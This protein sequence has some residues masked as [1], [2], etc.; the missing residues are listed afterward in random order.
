MSRSFEAFQ[1]IMDSFKTLDVI[2]TKTLAADKTVI[3]ITDMVNGFAHFGALSSPRVAKIAKPI[4][5]FVGPLANRG[6]KVI[7]FADAHSQASPEFSSY[8]PHCMKGT[9]ESELVP[10]IKDQFSYEL[11]EKNST[12]GYLEPRFQT[13]LAENNQWETFII[14]G[15]CTDICISQLAITLKTHF[16]RMDQKVDVMV[17]VDLVDTYDYGVHEGDLLHVM[18]LY[19]MQQ[20]GVFLYQWRR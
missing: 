9:P 10:E 1:A 16:N 17:P 3:I 18:G 7:A 4:A 20:N 14:V 19:M 12:N 11:I 15:N 5:D 13:L 6:V 8:P 2:E